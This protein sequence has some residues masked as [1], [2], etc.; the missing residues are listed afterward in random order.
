MRAGQ[1]LRQ[2]W[3][4]DANASKPC[5]RGCPH[6]NIQHHELPR[7]TYALNEARTEI[8][9]VPNPDYVPFR[10]YCDI[11]ECPCYFEVS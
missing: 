8:V 11:K 7:C 3:Q 9:E 5:P 10:F 6:L 4:D 2:K 1:A